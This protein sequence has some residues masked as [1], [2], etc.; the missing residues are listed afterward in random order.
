MFSGDRGGLIKS[1]FI[2][3]RE[4]KNEENIEAGIYSHILF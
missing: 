3:L 4:D 1:I 2:I